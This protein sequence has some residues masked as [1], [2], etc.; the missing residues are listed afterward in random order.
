M[1]MPYRTRVSSKAPTPL[2]PTW[3]SRPSP[4]P[5]RILDRNSPQPLSISWS[6]IFVVSI[7]TPLADTASVLVVPPRACSTSSVVVLSCAKNYARDYRRSA[8]S[9]EAAQSMYADVVLAYS[10]LRHAVAFRNVQTAPHHQ[11]F[12]FLRSVNWV[13]VETLFLKRPRRWIRPQ[14]EINHEVALSVGTHVCS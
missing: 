7:E 13:V 5:S 11:S 6:Y 8:T 4:R 3:M 12:I 14:D 10:I 9:L 2:D 1:S